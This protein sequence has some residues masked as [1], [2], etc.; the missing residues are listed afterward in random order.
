MNITILGC[1]GAYPEAG[2][3]TAGLLLES[4]NRRILLDCGSGVLAQLFRHTQIED[5]DA[6]VLTHYHADHIADLGCLQYS[7][8]IATQLGKMS[9]PLPIYGHDQSGHF[10]KLSYESYTKG[11]LI[12]EKEDLEIAGLKFRF[13]GTVHP[14]YNLAI[15]IESEGKHMVYTG[16]TAFDERLADFAADCD[17]LICESSLYDGQNG[18]KIGHCTAPE[19]GKIA[20]LA[21]AGR[22]ILTHLPHY[23]DRELLVEQASR[24]FAGPVEMARSGM[25]IT[26]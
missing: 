13:Q 1:W 11:H 4:A 16:D 10:F 20:Q 2:E 26:L 9:R 12:Q 21:R 7:A 22:L 6:V 17:L 5:L 23:G 18:D 14:E 24:T 15:R 8:L 3:A 25:R 19:A